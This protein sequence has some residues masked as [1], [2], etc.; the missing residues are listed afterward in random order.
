[1]P[2]ISYTSNYYLF[3]YYYVTTNN[4]ISNKLKKK[5]TKS[6]ATQWLYGDKKSFFMEGKNKIK[7]LN[8]PNKC[9]HISGK[10]IVAYLNYQFF[11]LN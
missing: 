3:Q 5:G 11:F 10:C 6:Q 1:M 8:K 2:I 9:I 4:N 7:N